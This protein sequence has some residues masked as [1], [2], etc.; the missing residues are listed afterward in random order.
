MGVVVPTRALARWAEPSYT[1]SALR[2]SI[3]NAG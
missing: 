1:V 3:A 2:A